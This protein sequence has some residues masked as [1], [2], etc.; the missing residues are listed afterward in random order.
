MSRVF[1][2][3]RQLIPSVTPANLLAIGVGL[4]LFFAFWP[5]FL[6]LAD[7]WGNDP[8]YSHGYLVPLFSLYLLWSR[9]EM[10]A[11]TSLVPSWIG[12]VLLLAGLGIRF[13]GS[14]LFYEWLGA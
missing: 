4:A 12:L 7:R 6:V 2:P 5:T 10:V 9:R 8:R 13:A 3:V 14:Y 11:Q 1:L